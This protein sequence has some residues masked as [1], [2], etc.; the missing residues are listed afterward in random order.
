MVTVSDEIDARAFVSILPTR[1][2]PKEHLRVSI[3]VP[4]LDAAELIDITLDS[5]FGQDYENFEV[6]I[7]DGGSRDRT[8]EFVKNRR[9]E[10]LRVYSVAGQ[11]LYEM[12]N[13]GSKVAG[14]R[15][16]N[17]VM[18]GDFYLH[19][20]VLATVMEVA[21]KARLQTEEELPDL[22][23]C[24]SVVRHGPEELK[25]LNRK[26]SKELL[27]RG[28]QPTSLQ[29][30]WIRLDTFRQLGLFNGDYQV[31]GG[32]DFLCRFVKREGLTSVSTTHVLLDFTVRKL[33]VRRIF[34]HFWETLV[35][36]RR[37]FGLVPAIRFLFIQK[38]FVRIGRLLSERFRQAFGGGVR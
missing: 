18:P 14:G 24:G 4:T 25:I 26:L 6:I 31:R 21:E 27:A 2:K 28:L 1:E 8:L 7:V 19:P 38:D 11:S 35:S 29:A 32:F 3:V 34:R 12:L 22:V 30:L 20:R 36:L 9:D 13:R 33:R 16:I 37:H 15:Y 5:L 23:R 10:R 17:F